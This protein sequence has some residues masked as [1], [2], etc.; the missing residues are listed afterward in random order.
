MAPNYA[1]IFM[2]SV[3]E[4]I[5]K[6]AKLKPRIWHRFIDDVFI[7]WT[8]GKK[9]LEEFLEYI[10][11]IHETIKFTAEYNTHEVPFLDT[12]VYK[13]NA[14]LA[15][16]VYH[17]QTNDKMYLHYSSAHPRSQKDVIPYSLFIRCRRI[18]TEDRHFNMEIQE[19]TKN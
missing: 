5:L 10:N 8:H 16:K 4:Q 11:Q 18:C 17:K 19:I 9:Q 7:V 2:H 6:N 3:E 12:L 14:R 1:I 15:T 13:L